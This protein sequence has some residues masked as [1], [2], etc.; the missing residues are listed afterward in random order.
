MGDDRTTLIETLQIL[1]TLPT[2]SLRLNKKNDAD[3]TPE[4]LAWAALV[5]IMAAARHMR[6]ILRAFLDVASTNVPASRILCRALFELGAT[7]FYACDR[8]GKLMRDGDRQGCWTL[9]G[10]ALMGN[11]YMVKHGPAG[12]DEAP[13]V[14]PIAVSEAVR[15]MNRP[16][17][18][19]EPERAYAVLCAGR[20]GPG[21]HKRAIWAINYSTPSS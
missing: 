15:A 19:D 21:G 13:F 20:G 9:W 5:Y 17:C 16:S 8:V 2:P 1:D 4:Q 18:S 7:A 14:M 10:Q 6:S 12:P 11:R 3:P